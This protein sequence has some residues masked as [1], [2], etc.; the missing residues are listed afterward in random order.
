MIDEAHIQDATFNDASDFWQFIDSD[1]V[2]QFGMV[3]DD[4]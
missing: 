4:H 3:R 1:A 2:R